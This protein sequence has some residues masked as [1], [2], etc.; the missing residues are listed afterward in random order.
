MSSH[1]QNKISCL[2]SA[3][4]LL[5]IVVLAFP[6]SGQ[7]ASVKESVRQGNRLYG[8]GQFADSLKMYQD[9][10]N[11]EPES[12]IV[13]F[14]AGTAFYKEKHYDEAMGHLQKAILSDDGSLRE[15][16]HYNLGNSF[17]KSGIAKEKADINAAITALQES[18]K[19]L[20]SALALDKKDQDAQY[21]YDFVNKELER[22]RSEQRKQQ[23]QSQQNQDGQKDQKQQQNPQS[24][25]GQS[26]AQQSG[27][28]EN[29]PQSK[30]G[31][32]EE[33]K[34][35]NKEQ[36]PDESPPSDESSKQAESGETPHGERQETGEQGRPQDSA[37][38]GSAALGQE[39]TKSEAQR[40]LQ[41]YQQTE[42]P[43]GL[44]HVF[45]EKHE[46]GAVI[47]DW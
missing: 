27:Q 28:Q 9:S 19:H 10:L 31:E 37:Q 17:Y 41:N 44:L 38:S 2:K 1:T 29:S 23:Q 34:Q 15:R 5:F 24:G 36:S 14:N 25:Q 39:L 4:L 8:Q 43:Q 26:G 20:A 22:L 16:A 40:L 30:S 47:R 35:Q 13:N 33:Q 42:E 11:K 6:R 7:A 46:T 3:G 18:L 45:E 12:D 32:A 21:N